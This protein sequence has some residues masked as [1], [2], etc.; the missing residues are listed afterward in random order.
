MADRQRV[1]HRPAI[2]LSPRVSGR[3]LAVQRAGSARPNHQRAVD[4][5][6]TD[7]LP[8]RV[9][10]GGPRDELPRRVASLRTGLAGF[11][12]PGSPVIYAASARTVAWVVS[13]QGWQTMSV[14]RRFL[15][16]SAAHPG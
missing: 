6:P 16:M 1:R 3:A 9:V 2:Q 14:L 4:N 15:A 5:P 7:A 13:W 12:A 8:E 10:Q 11:P